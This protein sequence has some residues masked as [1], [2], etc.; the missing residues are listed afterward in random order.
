MSAFMSFDGGPKE[1]KERCNRYYVQV[2][3]CSTC[4]AHTV[5]DALSFTS[6]REGIP[7]LDDID[8]FKQVKLAKRPAA[9]AEVPSTSSSAVSSPAKSE[10]K[11]E[12]S[13]P[14]PAKPAPV[15]KALQKL[16]A[17]KSQQAAKKASKPTDSTLSSF[18]L[19]L[20]KKK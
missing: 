10:V 15:N 1:K 16:L 20:N 17:K 8:V 18:L 2:V 14:A 11:P 13:K 9:Q 6:K 12:E 3:K 7:E 4:Q 5:L 19:D